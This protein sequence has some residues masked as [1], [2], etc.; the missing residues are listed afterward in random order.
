MALIQAGGADRLAL[1]GSAADAAQP[2][3][4]WPGREE[5]IR[6]RGGAYENYTKSRMAKSSGQGDTGSA[7]V[8]RDGPKA[9][10]EIKA[11]ERDAA[12]RDHAALAR[13]APLDQEPRPRFA[14]SDKTRWQGCGAA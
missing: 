9:I 10:G 7:E 5:P 13:V 4:S 12:R 14:G 2:L 11:A 8:A 6:G 3:R 1:L